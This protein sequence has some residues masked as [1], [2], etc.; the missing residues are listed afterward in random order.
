MTIYAIGDVQGCYEPLCAL[1]DKIRF[2]PL[3]DTLWLVGDLVNRG[4]AS[5]QTLRFV[6]QLGDAAITVLGNHDLHLLAARHKVKMPND[7]GLLEVLA[8]PDCDE[9]LNW[10][11]QRPLLHHDTS[12][13]YVMAHAGIAPIWSL[14]QAKSHAHELETVLRS[15]NYTTFLQNMYGNTPGHWQNDLQGWDRLRFICNAFTRMRYCRESGEMDFKNNRSPGS[16]PDDLKPWFALTNRQPIQE[17]IVFGHW[18][19]L[20]IHQA[21]GTYALDSGCVWG[22][23]L[24]ALKIEGE[25]HGEQ[26]QITAI[27][28]PTS[29]SPDAYA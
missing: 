15:E 27:Q 5:L 26:S 9:L 10:L 14:S 2:D 23:Q 8:A 3:Q 22:G 11:R 12:V 16:Q 17:K 21:N 20:G 24:S 4:P 29:C 1:L 28:C 13:N 25:A 19:T 7:Q 18:S 6:K